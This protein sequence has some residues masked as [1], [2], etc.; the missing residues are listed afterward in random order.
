M[1]LN[2]AKN[3]E[4]AVVRLSKWR[5]DPRSSW[6]PVGE[7]REPVRVAWTIVSAFN[8]IVGHLARIR[9]ANVNLA[10]GSTY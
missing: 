4:L 2:S 6:V 5:Y 9:Y 8:G 10:L 3:R 1:H 7:V